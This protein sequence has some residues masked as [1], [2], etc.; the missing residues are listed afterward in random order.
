MFSR[1]QHVLQFKYR[2]TNALA[3]NTFRTSQRG[4]CQ[5]FNNVSRLCRMKINFRTWEFGPFLRQCSRQVDYVAAQKV[6]RGQQWIRFYSQLWSR[7]SL[8]CL[9]IQMG[10]RLGIAFRHR[11]ISKLILAGA[12][13]SPS[14]IELKEANNPDDK[15]VTL[16]REKDSNLSSAHIKR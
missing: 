1:F 12:A 2:C 10:R 16:R 4:I 13:I 15:N 8:S 14:N 11:R 7:D 3:T 9:L 6:K 5:T